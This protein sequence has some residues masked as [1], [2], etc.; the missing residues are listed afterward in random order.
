MTA[1]CV[2]QAYEF[3][4]LW[5]NSESEAAKAQLEDR[6]GKKRKKGGAGG[7]AAGGAKDTSKAKIVRESRMV[8][9]LVYVIEVL[10]RQLLLL[11]KATKV[12]LTRHFK[13]IS[14][15]D[16]RIQYGHMVDALAADERADDESEDSDEDEYGAKKKK[17]K[18]GKVSQAGCVFS[19]FCF[20]THFSCVCSVVEGEGQ[21]RGGRGRGWADGG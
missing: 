10:E 7:G 21:G 16:F 13:R 4:P 19:G 3:V 6:K 11:S 12:D 2:R 8:P 5:Q 18:K 17:A 20:L 14:S 15:R 9:T 1:T